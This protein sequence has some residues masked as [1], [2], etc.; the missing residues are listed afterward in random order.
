[1]LKQRVITALIL[2]I[3]F[4]AAVF[5]LPVTLFSAFIAL[6]VLVGAWEWSNLSG[7]TKPLVRVGYLALVAVVML[8]TATYLDINFYSVAINIQTEAFFNVLMV[9][10]VWWAVALLLV[11]GYPSSAILWGGKIQRALM[12]LLVLVPAWVAFT[13]VRA[14]AHGE[15]LVLFIVAIVAF[16]DIGGYFTGRK[17][18]KRKLKVAVSPGKTWEGFCG[19]LL[20]NIFL[21]LIVAI[22]LG[23]NYAIV[24]AIVLPTSLISVLGDLL[25]SMVKRH[26]GVKDSSQLL[27]GHGGVL[28]RADSLTA[29]APIFALA[30]YASGWMGG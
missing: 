12:G 10:C 29:A 16:A 24:F 20:A 22:A 17:F 4:L 27:P 19:G 9:G 23:A 25:E 13:Y 11:Q 1:M 18:G 7:F 14:H 26:R 2:A 21:A 8:L 28:D 6:V 5:I 15:W 30:L 3:I